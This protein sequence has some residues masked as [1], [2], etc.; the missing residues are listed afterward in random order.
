MAS[1]RDWLG[2]SPPLTYFRQ[3]E[4]VTTLSRNIK[5]RQKQQTD[6]ELLETLLLVLIDSQ[7]QLKQM[8]ELLERNVE[9]TLRGKQLT[10]TGKQHSS[11]A[12]ARVSKRLDDVLENIRDQQ[13]DLVHQL[14]LVKMLGID[15][16]IK[17]T[18][19]DDFGIDPLSNVQLGA[20]LGLVLGR[21]PDK[22]RQLISR[23]DFCWVDRANE[24]RGENTLTARQVYRRDT[25]SA[26]LTEEKVK[27]ALVSSGVNTNL[28]EELYLR[29]KSPV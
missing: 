24:P 16:S 11:R 4:L 14:V 6:R 10:Q 18:L 21:K 26:G 28:A 13:F 9:Y 17:E 25:E 7:Q 2:E 1:Y 19:R 29:G 8:N 20:L 5:V 22:L 23:P 27:A 15:K 3:S 12:S